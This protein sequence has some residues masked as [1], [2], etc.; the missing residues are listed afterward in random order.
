M[1]SDSSGL[2]LKALAL[3]IVKNKDVVTKHYRCDTIIANMDTFTTIRCIFVANIDIFKANMYIFKANMYIFKANIVKNDEVFLIELD[4]CIFLLVKDWLDRHGITHDATKLEETKCRNKAHLL[5]YQ[6][7]SDDLERAVFEFGLNFLEVEKLN[8][9]QHYLIIKHGKSKGKAN[10]IAY[11]IVKRIFHDEMGQNFKVNALECFLNHDDCPWL[12]FTLSRCLLPD[13]LHLSSLVNDMSI[14]SCLP[15]SFCFSDKHSKYW[16]CRHSNS[17]ILIG[18]IQTCPIGYLV[19]SDG[20]HQLPLILLQKSLATELTQNQEAHSCTDTCLKYPSYGTHFLCPLI[21]S[22]I[23]GKL[24]SI[25]CFS[26]ILE[27]CNSYAGS[28]IN[29]SS[30]K[31]AFIYLSFCLCDCLML[32]TFSEHDLSV[33]QELAPSTN[34]NDGSPEI[35]TSI[36]AYITEK[37]AL[38]IRTSQ[39]NST[40]DVVGYGFSRFDDCLGPCCYSNNK[41]LNSAQN[42]NFNSC[43]KQ[44]GRLH[45]SNS[46]KVTASQHN[47][48]LISKV[49]VTEAKEL[50]NHVHTSCSDEFINL[51]NGELKPVLITFEEG[52]LY[53]L[54]VPGHTYNLCARAEQGSINPFETKFENNMLQAAA[55]RSNVR[56]RIVAPK[57]TILHKQNTNAQLSSSIPSHKR[58]HSLSEV[59]S[60]GCSE[61]I[62]SFQAV[63]VSY[64]KDQSAFSGS[65]SLAHYE[66]PSASIIS[67][68][69]LNVTEISSLASD[70][71]FKCNFVT[72]VYMDAPQIVYSLGLIPG[73]LVHFHRLQR[74]LSRMGNVY[75][76]FVTLS[77][78]EVIGLCKMSVGKTISMQQPGN[79]SIYPKE[80]LLNIWLK[81]PTV[82]HQKYEIECNICMF[83]RLTVKALCSKCSML[84]VNNRCRGCGNSDLY[85]IEANALILLDDGTSQASAKAKNSQL[86]RQLLTLT[87]NQWEGIEDVVAK[88]GEL[89]VTKVPGAYTCPINW[90]LSTLTNSPVVL[91][92][93]RMIVKTSKFTSW[94]KTVEE[95]N[96][97]GK[98]T[99]SSNKLKLY[100]NLTTGKVGHP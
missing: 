20:S 41:N 58:I 100:L 23:L 90:F 48:H 97:K 63:I 36:V 55:D 7:V 12:N 57:N 77:S 84:W 93:C 54:V 32:D 26:V 52:F 99:F 53:N 39:N 6:V 59:C 65:H 44:S 60:Q 96:I 73:A 98:N 28:S 11:C 42:K 95:S 71:D 56:L 35:L 75:F 68:K 46:P 49:K 82:C 87:E 72:S 10:N 94:A 50:S 16:I 81:G 4:N 33:A 66:Q 47:Y 30:T 13:V 51:N 37:H 43:V 67:G 17:Q 9:I 14:S 62:V 22:R 89:I 80:I 83:F 21:T 18:C 1:V 88:E 15:S 69:K 24:I 34:E 40:F 19:F 64:D 27:E 29:T 3:S 31:E 86:V 25:Q 2:D 79:V 92:P 70:G 74:K 5:S 61:S 76:R 8:E 45:F 91:R 78:A 38:K 85:F